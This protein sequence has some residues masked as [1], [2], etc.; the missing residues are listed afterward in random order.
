MNRVPQRRHSLKLRHLE[1]LLAVAQWGG[2]ARAAEHLAITQSVVSK[3]IADLENIVGVRLLD[4]TS[5]GIEPTLYGQALLKRSAALFNDVRASMSELEFLADPAGGEL[6]I[7]TTEP[8]TGGLLCAIFDRLSRRHPR[9]AFHVK[10]GD[11]PQLRDRELRE[12]EIDLIIGRIPSYSATDD[13]EVEFLLEE[14]AVVVVGV[15][16]PLTRRRNL[17]LKELINECWTLPPLESYPGSLIAEAFYACNLDFPRNGVTAHSNQMQTSMLATGRF[18][19]IL[20]A[21]MV[22]FSAER[23]QLKALPVKLAIRPWPIGIVTQ[24]NRMLSPIA[25]IFIDCAR[26]VAKENSVQKRRVPETA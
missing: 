24:K 17:Q 5:R 22:Q 2:M 18:V 23:L 13:I 20:P 15:R 11:P 3:A 9:A 19:T 1:V 6:R 7:G 10:L 16:N 4:R 12:R 25:R 21:T 14:Q 8:M 26:D